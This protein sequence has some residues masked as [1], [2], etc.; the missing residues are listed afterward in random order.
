MEALRDN[1]ALLEKRW[2]KTREELQLKELSL[3]EVTLA[4]D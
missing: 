4:A 2:Q 1:N 3:T